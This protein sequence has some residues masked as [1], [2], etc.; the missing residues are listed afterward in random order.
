MKIF[1]RIDAKVTQVLLIFLIIISSVAGF[2][3]DIIKLPDNWEIPV[4]LTALLLIVNMLKKLYEVDDNTKKLLT[5]LEIDVLTKFDKYDEFYKQLQSAIASAKISLDLTHIRNEPPS[6]FS[7]SEKYFDGVQDW[8]KK[9]KSG[10]LRRVT[11][12]SNDSMIQWVKELKKTEQAITNYH[13][14]ICEWTTSFPMVN[15]AIID[16]EMVFITLTADIAEKTSGILI[17]DKKAT[18]YFVQYFENIWATSKRI[19]DNL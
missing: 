19:P 15:M 7:N 2:F 5:N 10:Y 16:K 1:D 9:N 12:M 8:C 14:K 17:K 4:I 18:Q 11:T 13:I 6:A 3:N